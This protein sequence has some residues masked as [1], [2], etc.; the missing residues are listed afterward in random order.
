MG[1]TRGRALVFFVA[2]FLISGCSGGVYSPF[3]EGEISLASPV[4]GLNDA[5]SVVSPAQAGGHR[6]GSPADDFG[7]SW[8]SVEGD[9]PGY[10]FNP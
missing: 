5:K 8:E 10:N 1:A 4:L 9:Y 6:G 3:F 7:D 2:G